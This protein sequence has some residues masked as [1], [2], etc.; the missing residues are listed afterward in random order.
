M[1]SIKLW[2]PFP[3]QLGGAL[4]SEAQNK[5]NSAAKRTPHTA[6]KQNKKR[7]LEARIGLYHGFYV[8]LWIGGLER[9]VRYQGFPSVSCYLLCTTWL[10]CVR[11]KTR[12]FA[13]QPLT[14]KCPSQP[15]PLGSFLY[16]WGGTD[17]GNSTLRAIRVFSILFL[18][19]KH[20]GELLLKEM[21]IK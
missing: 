19:L 18:H 6:G 2:P 4:F 10:L 13:E 12:A 15:Q 7:C 1:T 16:F 11:M 8:L 3:K 17:K 21:G 9:R 5:W 14:S 20:L